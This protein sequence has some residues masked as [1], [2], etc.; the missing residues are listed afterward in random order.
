MLHE[1][2]FESVYIDIMDVVLLT[3]NRDAGFCIVLKHSQFHLRNNEIENSMYL[4]F[5]FSCSWKYID[6]NQTQ[7]L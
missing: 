7:H 5:R 2:D 1:G 3:E 6:N 4:F